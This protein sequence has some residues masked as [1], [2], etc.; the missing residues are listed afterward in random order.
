MTRK[1]TDSG[2]AER[3]KLNRTAI[4][5]RIIITTSACVLLGVVLYVL[6]TF[7]FFKTEKINVVSAVGNSE[8]S[9]YYTDAEIINAS[10]V[11]IGTGLFQLSPNK[12]AEKITTKLPYIGKVVIKRK[13]LSTLEIRVEDTSAAYGI[14]SNGKFIV[15]D[16]Y[17][18][19]LGVEKF[20]PRGAAR[21]TGVEFKTLENGKIA[22][23][24]DASDETRLTTL[25]D[26]CNNGGI[27]NI[28]KYDIENVASVKIIVNSRITVSFGTLTDISEKVYLAAATMER[29]ISNNPNAHIIIDVTSTDRSYVRNDTAEIEEDTIDYEEY[30]IQQE[31]LENQDSLVSVG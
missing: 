31:L 4:K 18:K 5:N 7:V 24:A 30:S 22:E 28:T 6:I 15:L 16:E 29:E 13:L 9:N 27:K 3:K 23:F 12:I 2:V 25:I 26:E 1:S 10:D 19:V 14:E 11:D 20:L 8:A 17:F 21:L